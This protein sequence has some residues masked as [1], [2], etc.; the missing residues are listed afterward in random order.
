MPKCFFDSVPG[1]AYAAS[2][3]KC[4]TEHCKKEIFGFWLFCKSC[5]TANGKCEICGMDLE[6][7][8]VTLERI[9]ECLN[10]SEELYNQ[11]REMYLDDLEELESLKTS[12]DKY[13]KWAEKLK[14][15]A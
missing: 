12:R 6:N 2:A 7:Y 5:S 10:N 15:R 14:T 11:F 8:P 1:M 3:K 13:I 4:S 9:N